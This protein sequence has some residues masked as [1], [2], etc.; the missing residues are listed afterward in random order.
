MD[1]EFGTAHVSLIKPRK[2]E[3]AMATLLH[4]KLFNKSMG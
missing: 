4:Q 1:F 2:L 3:G